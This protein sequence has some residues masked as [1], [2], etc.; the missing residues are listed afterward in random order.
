VIDCSE[1]VILSSYS[2][3]GWHKIKG[4][5]IVVLFVMLLLPPNTEGLLQTLE[6]VSVD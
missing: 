4:F 3:F 5:L 6:I 1:D 2:L